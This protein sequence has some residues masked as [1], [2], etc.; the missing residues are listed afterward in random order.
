MVTIERATRKIVGNILSEDDETVTMPIYDERKTHFSA[1]R[2]PQE[3]KR[4]RPPQPVGFIIQQE[5]T[6]QIAKIPASL[7]GHI[8]PEIAECYDMSEPGDLN[9]VNYVHYT[10]KREDGDIAID[11]NIGYM[12]RDLD[13]IVYETSELIGQP[14][15]LLIPIP[16][17]QKT[18]RA[19]SPIKE[20]SVEDAIEQVSFNALF[21]D[22]FDGVSNM[23]FFEELIKARDADAAVGI[24]GLIQCLETRRALPNELQT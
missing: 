13:T 14:A 6:T 10:V 5:I 1:E 9:V 12:L 22:Y 11:R 8:E 15:P 19:F 23:E 24:L 17:R 4:K 21:D 7:R 20:E 16:H 3:R 2:E 18:I